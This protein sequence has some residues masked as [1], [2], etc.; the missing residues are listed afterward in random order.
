MPA[1]QAVRQAASGGVNSCAIMRRRARVVV[2][3][4]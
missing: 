1:G 2:M 3:T 4:L